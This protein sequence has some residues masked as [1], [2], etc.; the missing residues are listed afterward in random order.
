VAQH[1]GV[2]HNNHGHLVVRIS[3]LKA[4]CHIP[5]IEVSV[6]LGHFVGVGIFPAQLDGGNAPIRIGSEGHRIQGGSAVP[7]TD[8]T[9]IDGIVAEV[10]VGHIPVLVTDQAVVGNHIGVE[11]HLDFG[12]QGD[13]LQGGGQIFDEELLGLV[14]VID[15]G[16]T[17]VAVVG[18]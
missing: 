17:A 9:S 3:L 7:G 13:H 10:L 8:L 6:D 11:I 18:Q 14:Q 1:L 16:I 15:V 5:G 12:I 4:F 2:L